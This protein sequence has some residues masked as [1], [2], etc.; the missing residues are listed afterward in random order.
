MNNFVRKKEFL[1]KAEEVADEFLRR[2]KYVLPTVARLCLI[3]TFLEDG[4]R[5]WYQWSE[6]R[7]YI[8]NQWSCGWFPAVLFVLINL[9]GQLSACVM[10]LGRLKVPIACCILFGIILLQTIGYGILWE[11]VFLMRNLAL[12]GGLVMVYVESQELGR[13]MFAGLPSM[14]EAGGQTR[15]YLQLSGRLLIVFMFLSLLR[16][17]TT[18]FHG[19]FYLVGLAGVALVAIGYKTKLC[20]LLLS[21]WLLLVNLHYN[22]W[23]QIESDKPV[24]DFMKYDFFQTMSVVGGLLLVVALGPGGV[25]F[26]N[27]KKEW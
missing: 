3:S 11:W 7:E 9:I 23:W 17:E 26:D 16:F 27:Y 13:S 1:D 5:M 22:A 6:Q 24:R 20:A 19:L 4:F 10:I 12:N 8:Q 18:F 15:S 21:F 25:S 14:G 2:S